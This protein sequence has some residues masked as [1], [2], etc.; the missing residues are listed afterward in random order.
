MIGSGFPSAELQRPIP[1][2]LQTQLRQIGVAVQIVEQSMANLVVDNSL[3][4]HFWLEMY[5]ATDPDP[6]SILRFFRSAAVGNTGNYARFGPG[7][8]VDDAVTRAEQTPEL[9]RS[10]EIAAEGLKALLEDETT[11][12]PMAGTYKIWAMQS[13]IELSLH[14]APSMDNIALAIK[15]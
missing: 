13:N 11:V 5:G 9:V 12:I 14:P 8:G 2:V 3:R 15:R 10:Q 7:G 6:G 1:E 4:A